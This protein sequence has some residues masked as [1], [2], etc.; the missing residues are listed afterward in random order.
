MNTS[1]YELSAL[2]RIIVQIKVYRLTNADTPV[3]A[4]GPKLD[5]YLRAH[6]SPADWCLWRNLHVHPE[7]PK[8][9][10]QKKEL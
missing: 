8:P 4:R 6:L 9:I 2:G 7:P 10:K 5:M 3:W 1:E